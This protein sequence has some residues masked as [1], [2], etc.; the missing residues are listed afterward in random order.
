MI[1]TNFLLIH[2]LL[3]FASNSTNK[4]ETKISYHVYNP[5]FNETTTKYNVD[6]GSFSY[7]YLSIRKGV[8]FPIIKPRI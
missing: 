3:V 8:K 2:L 4:C 7:S 1:K 5:I 6:C